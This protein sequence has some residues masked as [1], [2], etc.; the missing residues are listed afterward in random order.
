MNNDKLTIN[1]KQFALKFVETGGN[2]KASYVHAFSVAKLSDAQIMRGA[3]KTFGKPHVKE[4]IRELRTDISASAIFDVQ[5]MVNDLVLVISANPAELIGWH[6]GACRHC[7][8]RGSHYQWIDENELAEAQASAIDAGCKSLPNDMGGFGYNHTIAPNRKCPRCRGEGEGRAAL[9]DTRY[10][11][12]GASRLYQGVKIGS[13]GQLE[14]KMR[15]QDEAFKMLMRIYGVYNPAA[16]I[17]PPK[18][19][20]DNERVKA[21][22]QTVEVPNNPQAAADYYQNWLAGKQGTTH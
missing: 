7:Y 12:P 21:A 10:L 4:Y 1:E 5:Q 8:G 15:N 13:N 18:L 14:V 6:V 20:K 16:M 3:I 22:V 17:A 11:S 2:L 9:A 19:A